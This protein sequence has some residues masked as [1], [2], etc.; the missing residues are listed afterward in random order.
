MYK[1]NM[2]KIL[3]HLVDILEP[4][5]GRIVGIWVL[6]EKLDQLK[7]IKLELH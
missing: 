2:D 4:N 1:L 7:R 6:L 5:V 3:S